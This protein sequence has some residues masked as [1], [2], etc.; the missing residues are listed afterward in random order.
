[1]VKNRIAL[2]Q[3]PELVGNFTL[4]VIIVKHDVLIHWRI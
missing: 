1:M 3:F 2:V 4:L